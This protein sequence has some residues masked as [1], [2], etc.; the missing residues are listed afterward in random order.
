[1][2]RIVC[3]IIFA[4]VLPTA[5]IAGPC[6]EDKAKFCAEA[7]GEPGSVAQCLKEHMEELS[8]DC[9]AEKPWEPGPKE[10]Q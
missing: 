2:K 3:M 7:K 1:M 4:F 8:E 9:K 6:T 5:A 10:E